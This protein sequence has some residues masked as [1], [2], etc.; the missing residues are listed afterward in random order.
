[1]E[2]QPI[3]S[4]AKD[5]SKKKKK[6]KKKKSFLLGEAIIESTPWAKKKGRT[7]SD[8]RDISRRQSNDIDQSSKEKG[9]ILAL[10]KHFSR[11]L[12]QTTIRY[13]Y[14]SNFPLFPI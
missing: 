9:Q 8:A 13:Y 2:R 1:V 14:R 6:K 4:A 10:A 3:T 7:N 11:R 12:A 5:R